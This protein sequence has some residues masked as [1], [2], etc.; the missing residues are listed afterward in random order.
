M[1]D[2]SHLP[3]I[4]VDISTCRNTTST[5]NYFGN[6]LSVIY[7][8]NHVINFLKDED[9]ID[10]DMT[11]LSSFIEDLLDPEPEELH[12]LELV[13]GSDLVDA[14]VKAVKTYNDRRNK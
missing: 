6:S 13:H 9:Y 8:D 3:V 5:L 7:E 14:Y 11:H 2:A 10:Q 12:Y 1:L 4:E